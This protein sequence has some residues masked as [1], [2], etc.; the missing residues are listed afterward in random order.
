MVLN[1]PQLYLELQMKTPVLLLSPTAH[2]SASG[3]MWPVQKLQRVPGLRGPPL[4]MVCAP[5]HVSAACS[6]G[7]GASS[8]STSPDPPTSFFSPLAVTHNKL[9]MD[10]SVPGGMNLVLCNCKPCALVSFKKKIQNRKSSHRKSQK[11]GCV[12]PGITGKRKKQSI[13]W[14]PRSLFCNN[15]N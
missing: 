13:L 15:L 9:Q 5:Q 12:L 1:F 3:V 6:E 7:E 10:R 14:H 2:S 4:W 8:F 11:M